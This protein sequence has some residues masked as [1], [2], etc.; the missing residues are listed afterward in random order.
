MIILRVA[1]ISLEILAF[2]SFAWA[3]RHYFRIP[4]EGAPTGMRQLQ[5]AAAVLMIL[6]IVTGLAY[7]SASWCSLIAIALLLA[8]MALF[9]WTVQTNFERRFA[10]A[11][12]NRA[13]NFLV[14][15][16]PY[17]WIRHPFYTSYLLTWLA[18]P[19]LAGKPLLLFAPLIMF[20]FYLRA[21][22]LEETQFLASDLASRYRCYRAST[23][24]FIPRI[25]RK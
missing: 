12:T 7:P 2:A 21:A 24:M 6:Q 22:Q 1:A 11:F 14:Q 17:R 3:I 25:L 5:T 23:G 10:I 15:S 16:G 8:S 18:G 9:W 4:V 20:C 13:P 19:V